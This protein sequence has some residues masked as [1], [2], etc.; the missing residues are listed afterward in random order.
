MAGLVWCG[1]RETAR[2]T[3]LRRAFDLITAGDLDAAGELITAAKDDPVT[4]HF[5]YWSI[6]GAWFMKQHQWDEASWRFAKATGY[7]PLDFTAHYNRGFCLHKMGNLL[8][9]SDA[10]RKTL[11]L[12]PGFARAWVRLG[13]IG[14]LRERFAEALACYAYAASI[15]PDDPEAR[16]GYGTALS[17]FDSLESAE[18]E[19]R[20]AL[21]LDPAMVEAEMALGMVL[22]QAGKWREGWKRRDTVLK[23]PP[24]GAPWDYKPPSYFTDDAEEMRGKKVLLWSEQGHGDTIQ[25]SRYLPMVAEIA[26]DVT[27]ITESPLISLIDLMNSGA[28]V[29]GRDDPVPEF[30]LQ[31]TL[32]CL[33]G[34]FGTTPDNIP[35]PSYLTAWQYDVGARVGLCWH[36]GSRPHDPSAHADD[37]RRSVPWEM[38]EPLTRLV[39]CISLQEEDLREWGVKDWRDTAEIVAGL[40]LVITVDT[41][42]AHLAGSLGVP[43]WLLSRFAGCWRWMQSGATTPWYPSMRIYRQPALCE[44]GPVMRQVTEDLRKWASGG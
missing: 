27:L 19:F 24:F 18:T 16:C 6:A 22:L 7:R 36:G 28:R 3:A 2:V 17:V 43:T 14:L 15:A 13:H 11:T 8:D 1:R 40:D 33:P 25:F 10:Y 38:F 9:A 29:I 31:T 23:H 4:D 20:R 30:D 26:H 35:P 41:A 34:I 21:D 5:D 12:N 44:W 39:P 42:V 37:K 32:M